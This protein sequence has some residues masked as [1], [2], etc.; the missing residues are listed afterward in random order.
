MYTY[1]RTISVYG[2]NHKPPEL[3]GGPF[4]PRVIT[5]SPYGPGATEYKPDRLFARRVLNT[6]GRRWNKLQSRYPDCLWGCTLN[7]SIIKGRFHDNSD[8]DPFI[9]Y[10]PNQANKMLIDNGVQPYS[11]LEEIK[12][13]ISK[14]YDFSLEDYD[15]Y[16]FL[17]GCRYEMQDFI[18]REFKDAL[19][20][21]GIDNSNLLGSEISAES[22]EPTDERVAQQIHA[23]INTYKHEISKP[24]NKR[25]KEFYWHI[26]PMV[27]AL[28]H[29][30]L[31]HG[32]VPEFREKIL[33]GLFMLDEESD[34]VDGLELLRLLSESLACIEELNRRATIFLPDTFEDWYDYLEIGREAVDRCNFEDTKL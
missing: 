16:G 21:A 25:M 9:F 8:I 10:D 15:E 18:E 20:G 7:G 30:Q 5:S 4:M 14:G 31:G 19:L 11:S 12:E 27:L 17:K 1:E 33:D 23:F 3:V 28:F 34:G 2:E 32:R 6:L 13:W 22:F 24:A 26:P 29:P